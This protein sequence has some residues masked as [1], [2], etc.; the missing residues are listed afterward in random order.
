VILCELL[1]GK[2]PFSGANA[3]AMLCATLTHDPA[4]LRTFKPEIP[5]ALDDVLRRALAKTP[6]QRYQTVREM[7]ADLNNSARIAALPV[8]SLI[9]PVQVPATR[10]IAVLPL[11]NMSPDRESE[12]I[13]HGLAEELID[14]LMQIS[15]L[16]VVSRSS[17][18]QFRGATPDV[19]DI[20]KRLNA[21]L[22]VHGS[23]RRSGDNLR[24]SMQLSET[25]EG[26]QIWSQRFNA[27]V[28]DL[29]ALEDELTAAVLEKLRDQLGARLSG[30]EPERHM[31]NAEAYDLYLQAR[32]AFN[33]ETPADFHTALELFLRSASADP[34]FAPAFLGIVETH[35]RLDWYGL[36]PAAEAV[37][38]VK[39]AL[40]IAL[41]IE[42]DSVAGLCNLALMQ[43]G[44]D[45][46]WPAAGESFKRAL[47]TGEG[48]AAVHFH[49][50]LDYLTPLGRLEEALKHLRYAQRLDPL[51]PIVNTAVGGCLYRMRRW[52][53]SAEVLRSTLQANPGFGHSHW[54]LGR[55]LLEQGHG[56]EALKHFEDA[57][58]IMGPIPAALAELGYCYA[59]TGQR[60]RAHGTVQELQRLSQ[61]SWVSP[62]NPA[63]VYAGLGELTAAMACLE[64]SLEKK[65]RQLVWVNVDPRFDPLRQSER[66]APLIA[67]IGLIPLQP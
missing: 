50:G 37:P 39:S 14:G 33:R 34:A 61:R 8:S 23:L 11:I 20:G 36:E 45:W 9:V 28:G 4:S 3:T 17:S 58:K 63:L 43:A 24:L 12:Y 27:H 55:V 13:C 26:V 7:L 53:E 18:F 54:S 66:Y 25:D 10:T 16:R 65:I 40:S 32:F 2:K 6:A 5:A 56:D 21:K 44:W 31:P 60:N 52:E 41:E 19:R 64:E 62:L 46:N 35:M 49:Y 1:I 38:A 29:F 30:V 48:S 67:R 47:T 15:G 59:R 51:S 22:V 57:V 42:P